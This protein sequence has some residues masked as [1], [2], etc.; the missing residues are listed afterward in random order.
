MSK[1]LQINSTNKTAVEAIAN[2]GDAYFNTD[3][4]E[5]WVWDTTLST[6]DWRK[7]VSSGLANTFINEFSTLFNATTDYLTVSTST[8]SVQSL[9]FWM[10]PSAVVT[11][12][13]SSQGLF[14]FSGYNFDPGIGSMTS[15]SGVYTSVNPILGFSSSGGG[16]FAT[17]GV[18]GMPS[19]ITA[20][21]HHVFCH[22][23]NSLSVDSSIAGFE[24][25]FDG[26][27]VTGDIKG[28]PFGLTF[29]SNTRIGVRGALTKHF[30]G[31][32][33]EVAIWDT[34]ASAHI[35]EIYNGGNG[36]ANLMDLSTQPVHWW[37]MGDLEGV[38]SG[39]TLTQVTDRGTDGTAHA[40]PYSTTTTIEPETP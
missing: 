3:S 16:T 6:P 17:P 4:S 1:F 14:G 18:N 32:M 22:W 7:Y 25:Y 34:D 37:R 40:T 13:S 20:S 21:W 31:H 9:S 36:P 19:S 2:N 39:G 26:Q 8:T 10:K 27:L 35:T 11:N 29:G 33:D 23:T 24:I 28:T 12:T 15:A 30:S 5:I 38:A